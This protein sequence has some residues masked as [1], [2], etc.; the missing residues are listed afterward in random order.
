MKKKQ[1]LMEEKMFS[2]LLHRGLVNEEWQPIDFPQELIT[3]LHEYCKQDGHIQSFEAKKDIAF[4]TIGNREPVPSYI[5]DQVM[6]Y[7]SEFLYDNEE[8]GIDPEDENIDW[9]EVVE[10]VLSG[11]K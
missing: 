9:D 6:E 10:Q 3:A 4:D 7:V 11:I 8:W 1:Y 5:K 2:K